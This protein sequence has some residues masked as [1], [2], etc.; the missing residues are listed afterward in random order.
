VTHWI[1]KIVLQIQITIIES[2]KIDDDCE[3]EVK[4]K[5]ELVLELKIDAK[6]VLKAPTFSSA[7]DS[8]R[9]PVL[10][11]SGLEDLISK[12]VKVIV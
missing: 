12:M 3:G 1:T 6:L 11:T 7:E 10:I 9:S 5:E 4:G 8:L 2:R